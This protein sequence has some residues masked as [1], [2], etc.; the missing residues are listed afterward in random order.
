MARR[1]VIGIICLALGVAAGL[2]ARH[3]SQRGARTATTMDETVA[4][5][6]SGEPAG[7]GWSDVTVRIR[8]ILG[9]VTVTGD[10]DA[11]AVR[12]EVVRYG[13]GRTPAE[14][15]AEIR[16]IAPFLRWSDDRTVVIAGATISD[17][18]ILDPLTT[19]RLIVPARASVSIRTDVAAVTIRDVDGPVDVR[20][21]VGDVTVAGSGGTV[22]AITDAG[23]VDVAAE[24]DVTAHTDIG[25]VWVNGVEQTS[26]LASG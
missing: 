5:E 18:R 10:P 8:S 19:W 26:G 15:E 17:E 24:G 16:A 12:A 20:T 22:T 6:V 25:R 2:G 9:D 7:E 14:A 21:D 3:M 23:D 13:T 1:P 4:L 11:D